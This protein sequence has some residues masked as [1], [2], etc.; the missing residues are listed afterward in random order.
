[1]AS[2]K[3]GLADGF[4][5][6]EELRS[7]A[8]MAREQ[9]RIRQGIKQTHHN[10]WADGSAAGWV[11]MVVYDEAAALIDLEA[12]VGRAAWVGVDMSKSYDLTAIEVAFRDDDDGYTGFP[13]FRRGRLIAA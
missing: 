10:V 6:L 3:P 8:M 7:E 2:G 4:P 13:S 12:L 11:E 9:P 1:M 5:D